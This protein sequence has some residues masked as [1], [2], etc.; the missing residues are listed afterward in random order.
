MLLTTTITRVDLDT[1]IRTRR[2][3][4]KYT[5]EPVARELIADL[6]ETAVWTPNHHLTEPWRFIVLT[7]D[8]RAEYAAIRSDMA[9]EGAKNT[10]LAEREQVWEGTYRKFITVPA[11]IFVVM[12][13]DEQPNVREEDYAA[14]AAL[15]QN[16]LLLAWERGVGT[17]WKTY[18]PY[19]PLRKWLGLSD[20]EIV[21]GIVQLGYPAELPTSTR[22]PA[23]EK[24]EWR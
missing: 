21:V 8:G 6:L 24:T 9:L 17:C 2:T 11:Y 18:K 22:T 7:G 13:E 16:I 3:I 12:R 10:D 14:T 5:D 4:S 23:A 15:I 1:L 19:A 20:D